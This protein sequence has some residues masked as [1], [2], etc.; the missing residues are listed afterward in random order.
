MTA[1]S[2]NVTTGQL[3]EAFTNLQLGKYIKANPYLEQILERVEDLTG[4][5]D[6]N[7]NLISH[8]S[9]CRDLF[10]KAVEVSGMNPFV[11]EVIL[12]SLEMERVKK[13]TGY[14][15]SPA[16]LRGTGQYVV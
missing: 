9:K 2:Y 11:E 14:I 13:E 3:A 16:M 12:D 5:R 1:V 15:V 10:I 6:F 7:Y 8:D 4:S